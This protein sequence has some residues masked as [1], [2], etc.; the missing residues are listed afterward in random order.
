MMQPN[1]GHHTGTYGLNILAE[2]LDILVWICIIVT[3][4]YLLG[5]RLGG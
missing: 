2:N 4:M 5:I 1:A 3:I